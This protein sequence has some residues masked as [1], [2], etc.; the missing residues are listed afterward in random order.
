MIKHARRLSVASG[1]A[2][3]SKSNRS[4]QVRSAGAARRLET[5]LVMPFEFDDL[6]FDAQ[7]LTLEIGERFRVREGAVDFPVEFRFEMGMP[8]AERFETIQ[9]RHW[10]L[11]SSVDGN[12]PCYAENADMTNLRRRY[13]PATRVPHDRSR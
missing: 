11:Q 13:R 1:S 7:L 2:R 8:G 6:V 5:R 9:K 3:Q 10:L 4:R 12:K